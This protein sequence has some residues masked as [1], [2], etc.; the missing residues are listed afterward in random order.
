MVPVH[1]KSLPKVTQQIFDPHVL[2]PNE[3]DKEVPSPHHVPDSTLEAQ[4]QKK[5]EA[6]LNRTSQTSQ[7]GRHKNR[8]CQC[9]VQ[10][11]VLGVYTGA[12]RGDG[13]CTLPSRGQGQFLS[14]SVSSSR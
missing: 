5:A 7:E 6:L 8:L 14:H 12:L 13:Q 3:L 10:A 4:M 9:K 2:K 1:Y 11:T